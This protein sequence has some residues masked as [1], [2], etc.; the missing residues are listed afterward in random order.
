[1]G[2]GFPILFSLREKIVGDEPFLAVAV[3]PQFGARHEEDPPVGA[4]LG[5]LLDPVG[6][7]QNR[8]DGLPVGFAVKL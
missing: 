8:R 2:F 5:H 3:S 7:F 4:P 1:L 6:F